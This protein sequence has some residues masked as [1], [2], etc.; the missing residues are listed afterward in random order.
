MNTSNLQAIID[1]DSEYKFKPEIVAFAKTISTFQTETSK[2]IN[3]LKKTFDN[4]MG[5]T[6]QAL[7]MS[8]DDLDLTTSQVMNAVAPIAGQ[9]DLLRETEKEVNS[10]TG[11]MVEHFV[12]LIYSSEKAY[13]NPPPGDA[14]SASVV[15]G[16][17]T[18]VNGL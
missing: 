7:F 11:Q 9:I 4:N 1:N 16:E 6:A 15:F 12:N 17:Q 10:R 13:I 8:A 2:N 5:A 3:E 18:P 14:V